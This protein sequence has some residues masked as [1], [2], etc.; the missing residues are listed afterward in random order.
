[1][2]SK[3][4]K[5]GERAARRAAGTRTGRDAELG[6]LRPGLAA[7]LTTGLIDRLGARGIHTL[8][9]LSAVGGI[10][11]ATRNLRSVK[12]DPRLADELDAQV[13]LSTL[14]T[15]AAVNA[16]LIKAGFTSLDRIADTP[17]DEFVSAVARGV[18]GAEKATALHAVASAQSQFLSNVLTGAR[19]EARNGGSA[20]TAR[21]VDA[22]LPELCNCDC[23]DA[24][25]P[26][27]YLADL[28]DYAI[29]HLQ[30]VVFSSGLRG[31][32]FTDTS[33]G[34]KALERIDPTVDFDWGTGSP[35]AALPADAYSVRWAGTVKPPATGSYTFFVA[36]DDGVRGVRL[37]VDG[38]LVVNKSSWGSVGTPG[39]PA[40]RSGSVY[41]EGSQRYD[42]KLE[43]VESGGTAN[44]R[45]LWASSSLAKQVV[46]RSALTAGVRAD[47]ITLTFLEDRLH[48][49]FRGLSERCE[50]MQDPIR[51]VRIACEVLRASLPAAL[52]A[53]QLP[54][55]VE[56]V[57]RFLLG[58]IGT[59]Y[60]ELGRA[61]AGHD[62]VV[63]QALLTRLGIFQSSG[64]GGNDHLDDLF[65]DVTSAADMT[66][67]KLEDIFGY[68][69]TTTP[70]LD[71][72]FKGEVVSW[73]LQA[74][75]REWRDEDWP[76][77]TPPPATPPLIDPDLVGAPD[78]QDSTP[79][80]SFPRTPV[81]PMD[82]F[83]DRGKWVQQK[84][85]DVRQ[86]YDSPQAGFES[87]ITDT[88]TDA[89]GVVRH[90]L[91]GLGTS[92]ANFES[93]T[94]Q[95]EAGDD[96][97]VTIEALQLDQEGFDFLAW[98]WQT[99]RT[100]GGRLSGADVYSVCSILVQRLKRTMFPTWRGEERARDITLSQR[101]FR[102]RTADGDVPWQSVPFRGSQADRRGWVQRLRA[103]IEREQAVVDSMAEAISEAEDAYLVDLRTALL[104]L[105]AAPGT[106]TRT[107]IDALTDR[108]QLDLDQGACQ[109]T[110]RVAQAIDTVQSVLF[111]ARNWLLGG[112]DLALDDPARFDQAWRWIG[113]YSAWRAAIR[114]F[115]NP[116]SALRPTLRRARSGAFDDMVDS[117]RAKGTITPE[118]AE[119]AAAEYSSYFRDICS[120]SF[121]ALARVSAPP[122]PGEDPAAAPIIYLIV[123]RGGFTGRLYF[124][125]QDLR[126]DWWLQSGFERSFWNPVPGLDST[127]H[128]DHAFSYRPATGQSAACLYVT[129]GTA[130]K[131]TTSFL[132][133]DGSQWSDT[134]KNDPPLL[135]TSARYDDGILPASPQ[136][137]AAGS[138]G[139][140]LQ[141]S[142]RIIALDVDGDGRKELVLAAAQ[143]DPADGTR[144]FGI[145]R[146]R[147]GGLVL[148][149]EARLPGEW[150]LPTGDPVVVRTTLVQTPS[151]RREQVLVVRATGPRDI[152][153]LGETSGAQQRLALIRTSSN[154]SIPGAGGAAAWTVDT[155]ATFAVADIDGDGFSETLAVQRVSPSEHRVTILDLRETG[156]AV[157]STQVIQAIDDFYEQPEDDT[158]RRLVAMRQG[159]GAAEALIVLRLRSK[160]T[161]TALRWNAQSKQ[162]QDA[163]V[164]LGDAVFMLPGSPQPVGF[165]D[166]SLSGFVPPALVWSPSANDAFM[167]AR[168]GLRPAAEGGELVALTTT[169]TETA[170]FLV[171]ATD[172]R[173]IW[174]SRTAIPVAGPIA[175][176][177]TRQVAD[178][179]VAADLDGDGFQELLF[180]SPGLDAAAVAG[181]TSA[182]GI[183]TRASFSRVIQDARARSEGGWALAA[184]S[185][186]VVG[187]L[188]GDGCEEVVVAAGGRR[189]GAARSSAHAERKRPGG[190]GLLR[191]VRRHRV[192]RRRRRLPALVARPACRDPACL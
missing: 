117:L 127:A 77:P 124:C 39:N 135:L 81:R 158:W 171:R 33:F 60:D 12:V 31:E 58:Q 54:S 148:D 23:R 147:G 78:I 174:R 41:L 1:M 151:R 7:G 144:R 111:G 61:V 131:R 157:R 21:A 125:T 56:A 172:V 45:L 109:T 137:A 35:A 6:T 72:F 59:T 184:G 190:A 134:W 75:Q 67:A 37:W 142:D 76:Q 97:S 166:S 107:Q 152:A 57:Y 69:A 123:A 90:L 182:A 40:E 183:G 79:T 188:D 161:I 52:A 62:K 47:P 80:V 84:L 160:P 178:S 53:N 140:Q 130:D 5:T 49:P 26:V 150:D 87:L 82:F 43:Y 83:E 120:L 108:L 95:R 114:I 176:D 11:E 2:A 102:L 16:R 132:T 126:P 24:S 44:V 175:Q 129:T 29:K 10:R 112:H 68:R 128:V 181:R 42:L 17:R 106:I 121:T 92:I 110:T 133:Y 115:L 192:R 14:P 96:I 51:Q 180:V 143:A 162:L 146:E 91:L 88:F 28:L 169:G 186:Y 63:R 9:D 113:S 168:L 13:R 99:T 20:G 25:S 119:S 89:N 64:G 156:F 170:V 116:E 138:I 48:Q 65:L 70:P 173:M 73:R 167:P 149:R 118:D 165:D 153:L 187:D 66:E 159:G 163:V 36:A 46:P 22:V 179:I 94:Q 145:L 189:R 155:G 27:A 38:Q 103:R 8:A 3:R 122:D 105:L 98:A 104:N 101:F 177:W 136:L 85:L 164:L 15:T 30:N 50:Y 191:P 32:Y 34:A 19:V 93:L 100:P 185:R 55:Y 141:Q 71:P 4:T 18:G 86:A 74:L 154:S 139:W